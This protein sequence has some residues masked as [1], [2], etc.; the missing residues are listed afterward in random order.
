MSIQ[1]HDVTV[2]GP[3]PEHGGVGSYTSDLAGAMD[4]AKCFHFEPGNNPLSYIRILLTGIGDSNRTLHFQY[5]YELFGPKGVYT[6]IILPILWIA[7]RL[8]HGSLIF[9]MHEVWDE[10]DTS[11]ITR[12]TYATVIHIWLATFTDTLVFLSPEARRVYEKYAST[13]N[14]TIIPHG[15][16]RTDTKPIENPKDMFDLSDSSFLVTQHGFVNK[17]KGFDR[18]IEIAHCFPDVQFMIAG[19]PRTAEFKG[20]YDQLRQNAPE[21]VFFTGVLN[22]KKFH[23]AFQASDLVILPYRSIYQSGIFSWSAAYGCSTVASRIPYFI[24]LEEEYGA[25]VTF[26]TIDEA[27]ELLRTLQINSK[28]RRELEMSIK[29]HARENSF[30]CVVAMHRDLYNQLE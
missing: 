17:R 9:T 4:F 22:N 8:R 13:G 14:N 30:E 2:I 27:C 29:S 11:G 26:E 16:P 23:A 12:S 19:G 25:P 10:D 24:D 7:T 20:Y 6:L 28:K 21:N 5:T 3:Y 15:V 1:T 18:F